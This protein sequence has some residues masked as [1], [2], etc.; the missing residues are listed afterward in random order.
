MGRAELSLWVEPEIR[1]SIVQYVYK[2]CSLTDYKTKRIVQMIGIHL[3][4]F[5]SWN[6]RQ[7][8]QNCHNCSQPKGHWLLDHEKE[9]LL[10]YA[11]DH[12]G[13]GYRRLTYMMMDEDV[14]AVS[15]STTYRL[16]K[17][18]GMLN[19]WNNIRIS[20]KGTGFIQPERPHEH[21]HTDIK[22]VNFHGTFLFL[23]SVIDGYSRYIVHHELRMNMQEYDV[24]LTLQ[25]APEKYPD[26]SP[27]LIT[28]NG[29]QF[30]SRDFAE[31]LKQAGLNHIRTSVNY[32]QSNGKIERFHRTISEEFLRKQSMISL[33]DA[34]HQ[35][36]N[37]IEFYNTK[38]LHS[39][40]YYLTPEDFLLGNIDAKI[41]ARE[42]K[43]KNAKQAR[44]M[45]RL[46]S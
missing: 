28:D 33:D 15:P 24:Q 29:S 4:K 17:G 31:Y 46:A 32:P 30:I 9:A 16:L 3:S 45:K 42:V 14:V 12:M 35:V 38:R 18:Y 21:W 8:R 27:R 20:S 11:K 13:E 25:R 23:I 41:Q 36:S 5:Y 22:Y 2:I 44:S 19:E 37:Y 40:L 39:S 43:L 26:V 34:R 6:N 7:G 1:D 10:H